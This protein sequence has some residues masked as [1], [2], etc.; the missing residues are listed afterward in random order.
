LANFCEEYHMSKVYFLVIIYSCSVTSVYSASLIGE[1]LKENS[2]IKENFYS[3][4][5]AELE[6]A[7]L[8]ATKSW[9]IDGSLSENS[10]RLETSTSNTSPLE[11]DYTYSSLGVSKSFGFG[12]SLSLTNALTKYNRSKWPAATIG[13]LPKKPYVFSQTLSVSQDLG[14]NFFGR[15]FN[16]QMEM[17]RLSETYNKSALD[18]VDQKALLTFY[19]AY[20]SARLNKT[21]INLQQMAYQRSKRRQK[22]VQ[23]KVNDGLKEKVDLYQ[24]QISQQFQLESYEEAR[25]DFYS[26]LG[27]LSE[28][29]NR[30]ITDSEIKEFV[31]DSNNLLE[32]SV[33][34]KLDQHIE[35]KS[36]EQK[37]SYLNE[38]ENE[39]RLDYWPT[40]SLATSY[41]TNDYDKSFSDSF[42]T[43]KLGGKNREWSVGL[44]VSYPLGNESANV[45]KSEVVLEK[46]QAGSNLGKA[47]KSIKIAFESLKLELGQVRKNVKSAETRR[48]LSKKAL[49]E[50]N[51]LY[52]LGRADL[53]RVIRAEEDLISTEKSFAAHLAKW[54]ILQAKKV[55]YSNNLVEFLMYWEKTIWKN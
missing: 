13:T 32:S 27:T 31:L 5:I 38:K 7:A 52:N 26:S 55:Y 51:R 42:N 14:K 44:T 48:F 50:T 12:T 8:S 4:K 2:S 19:S 43:G 21:I 15:E 53:D 45:Q 54:E 18:L 30:S 37:L 33:A 17:A 35:I 28:S 29:V 36:L 20:V 11:T 22:D 9:S 6:Q 25:K 40:V 46:Q 34:A 39:V 1:F 24:S 47:K 3:S 10:S 49:S 23:R 16:K 41:Q